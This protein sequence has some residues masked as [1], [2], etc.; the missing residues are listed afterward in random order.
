MRGKLELVFDLKFNLQDT[1]DW[2][3]TCL[4]D[5]YAGKYQ[6]VLFD[7]SHNSGAIDAKIDEFLLAEKST[8]KM[9]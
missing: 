7:R 3:R 1:V 6:L 4:V 2:G 8:F 9:L 5:F